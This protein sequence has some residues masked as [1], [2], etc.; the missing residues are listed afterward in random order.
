MARVRYYKTLLCLVVH[1]FCVLLVSLVTDYGRYNIFKKNLNLFF[2]HE[3]IKKRAS[4]VAHNRPETFFRSTAR[5]QQTSPELKTHLSPYL[6][7]I[8]LL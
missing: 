6:W 2:A 5:L 4:K 8:V 7:S 3:N 1:V